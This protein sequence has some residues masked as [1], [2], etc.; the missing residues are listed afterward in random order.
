MK[1]KNSLDNNI[2]YCFWTGTNLMSDKRKICLQQLRETSKCNVILVIPETLNNYIL[3]EHPLHP[4]FNYLSETH[5]ADYLRTY[6]MRFQINYE[7]LC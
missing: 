7:L 6:F 1:N 2:I 5:K 3:D 4:S